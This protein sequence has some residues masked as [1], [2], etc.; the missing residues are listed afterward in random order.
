MSLNA[1]DLLHDFFDALV[2]RC[3]ITEEDV[4]VRVGDLI[5]LIHQLLKLADVLVLATGQAQE[6]EDAALI[7][8]A[9]GKGRTG[10]QQLLFFLLEQHR[11]GEGFRLGLLDLPHREIHVAH[12]EHMKS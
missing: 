3:L 12:V 8:F 1:P 6:F 4:P 10:G 11:M 2:C 9:E 5:A 7:D